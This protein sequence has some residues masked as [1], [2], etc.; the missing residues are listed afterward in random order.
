MKMA[1]LVEFNNGGK[2]LY[3]SKEKAVISCLS[4]LIDMFQKGTMTKEEYIDWSTD[5]MADALDE[6]NFECDPFVRA[7][8]MEVQ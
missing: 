7:T 3:D 8:I 4:Y 6:D 5:L 1:W 2:R